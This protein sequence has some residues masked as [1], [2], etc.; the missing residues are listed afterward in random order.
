MCVCGVENKKY[1][2]TY[3][4][5]VFFPQHDVVWRE[6]AVD[7]SLLLVQVSQ[8]QTHLREVWRSL[9]INNDV[10]ERI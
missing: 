2:L 8:R 3:G 1:T 9:L 7:D 6:V 10:V 4:D 5:F